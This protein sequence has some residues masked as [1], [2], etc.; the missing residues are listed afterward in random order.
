MVASVSYRSQGDSAL[1][2]STGCR[3]ANGAAQTAK[4]PAAPKPMEVVLLARREVVVHRQRDLLRVDAPRPDARGDRDL[5]EPDRNSHIAKPRALWSGSACMAKTVK[6][7][8]ASWP[9]SVSTL[10]VLP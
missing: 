7:R 10:P 9:A 1:Q 4:A 3:E 2:S 5:V 6:T 8:F